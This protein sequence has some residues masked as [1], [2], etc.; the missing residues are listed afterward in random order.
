MRVG[1]GG[2]PASSGAPRSPSLCAL[3]PR[4]RRY[5]SVIF[6]HGA[7]QRRAAEAS[8]ASRPRAS[9]TVE[10]GAT[11]ASD[12]APCSL[13]W[14]AEAYHQKWLLQRKRPLFLALGMSTLDE[15]LGEPATVLN[16]AAAGKLSTRAAGERLD[17]ALARREIGGEAHSAARALLEESY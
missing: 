15:L 1:I 17:G 9:T 12:D 10:D 11:G 8:L 5:S 16:A 3:L 14:D 2:R 7:E 6:A 4:R 13:F